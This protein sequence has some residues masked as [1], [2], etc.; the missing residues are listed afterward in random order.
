MI[1]VRTTGRDAYIYIIAQFESPQF[2]KVYCEI[3]NLNYKKN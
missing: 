1:S 2:K 3:N